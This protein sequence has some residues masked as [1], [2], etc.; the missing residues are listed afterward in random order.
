M[1]LHDAKINAI[2]S[3]LDVTRVLLFF[4]I[5]THEELAESIKIRIESS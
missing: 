1:A 2:R 4:K 5:Q 3:S